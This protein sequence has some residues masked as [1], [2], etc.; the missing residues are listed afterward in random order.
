MFLCD[1]PNCEADVM[2]D[3]VAVEHLSEMRESGGR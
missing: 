3:N 2:D 1:T